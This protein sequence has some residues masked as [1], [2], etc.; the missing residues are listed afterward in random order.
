MN[1]PPSLSISP[2]ISPPISLPISLPSPLSF[3]LSLSPEGVLPCVEVHKALP[4]MLIKPHHTRPA[5]GGVERVGE[6]EPSNE[7][8]PLGDEGGEGRRR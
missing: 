8:D 1:S 3:A 6:G 7:G 5:L 4:H 2:P